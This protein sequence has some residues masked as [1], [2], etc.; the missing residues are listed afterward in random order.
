LDAQHVPANFFRQTRKE[1]CFPK[2]EIPWKAKMFTLGNL[3]WN[4]RQV[5]FRGTRMGVLP[6]DSMLIDVLWPSFNIEFAF[7]VVKKTEKYSGLH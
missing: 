1:K 7:S 4:E 2:N 5:P 3:T 6:T